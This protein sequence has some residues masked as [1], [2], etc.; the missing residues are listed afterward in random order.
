M[1][2]AIYPGGG[3]TYAQATL[4]SMYGRIKSKWTLENDVLQ[5][6]VSIPPNSE[7]IVHIPALA[8]ENISEQGRP[9]EQVEGVSKIWQDGE[10]TVLHIGSG[11]YSFAVNKSQMI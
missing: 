7:A 10:T 2:F 6:H 3:L 1:S 4:D 11:Q 8:A 9:L 5:L